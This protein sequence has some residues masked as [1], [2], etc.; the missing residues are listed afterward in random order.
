MVFALKLQ[1]IRIARMKTAL[2]GI[3]IVVLSWGWLNNQSRRLCDSLSDGRYCHSL[4]R[5][6]GSVRGSTK[7]AITSLPCGELSCR[8]D[9][10]RLRIA[11][12][13]EDEECRIDY[14]PGENHL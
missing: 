4:L 14:R 9:R 7:E 5:S 8:C 6:N 10:R 3:A 11:A 1:I 13:K 12:L 2:T